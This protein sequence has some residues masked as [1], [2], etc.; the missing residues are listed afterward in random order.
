MRPMLAGALAAIVTATFVAPVTAKPKDYTLVCNGAGLTA[1]FYF[2]HPQMHGKPA[3]KVSFVKATAAASERPS[4]AGQCAWVDR[5]VSGSEPNAFFFKD[6]GNPFTRITISYNRSSAAFISPRVVAQSPR[7]GLQS[8]AAQLV[9]LLDK[10][11][12]GQTFYVQ[13]H[14]EDQNGRK[15]FV[16]SR[17][18]P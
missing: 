16:M 17:F 7:G 3:V 6:A 11:S 12:K 15:I 10:I 4:A 13:V 14:S 5:P 18:G 2:H 8:H 1:A 9:L